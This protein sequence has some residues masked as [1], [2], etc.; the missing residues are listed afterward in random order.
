MMEVSETEVSKTDCKGKHKANANI[1]QV[2]NQA[3]H[4]IASH[5]LILMSPQQLSIS[6]LYVVEKALEPLLTLLT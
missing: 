4:F 6:S 2:W 5:I 3:I 1:I